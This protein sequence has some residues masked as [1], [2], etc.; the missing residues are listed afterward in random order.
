MQK[1]PN[2]H[3]VKSLHHFIFHPQ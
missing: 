3:V 1:N 2:A